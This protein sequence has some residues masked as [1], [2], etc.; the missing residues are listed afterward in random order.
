MT[1]SH[2]KIKCVIAIKTILLFVLQKNEEMTDDPFV[3]Q[4]CPAGIIPARKFISSIPLKHLI[5][6]H[7]WQ[8][9][10]R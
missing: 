3:Q 9:K 7:F 8:I 5:L 2:L 6:W 10:S 1:A 4:N